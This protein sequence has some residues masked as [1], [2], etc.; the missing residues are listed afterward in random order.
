MADQ[1]SLATVFRSGDHSAREDAASIVDLLADAGLHPSQFNDDAIG[2]PI[3]AS[4]VRVP[5]GEEAMALEVIAQR[6]NA[7]R[8]PGDPGRALDLVEVFTGV[9]A[10]GEMEAIS[11]RAVLDANGIPSVM[12]GSSA[13]PNFP[14]VVKVSGTLA[15]QARSAIEAARQAGPEAADAAEAA[16]EAAAGSNDA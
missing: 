15:G 10:S 14:F 11:I 8:Q 16:T 4:E 9:G 3:G 12:V 6:D 7:P 13:V 1:D 2:V 5:A